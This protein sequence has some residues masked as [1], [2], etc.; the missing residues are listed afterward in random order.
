MPPGTGLRLG[1]VWCQGWLSA[2]P[3]FGISSLSLSLKVL[4]TQLAS[5]GEE[6]PERWRRSALGSERGRAGWKPHSA[7]LRLGT[8]SLQPAHANKDKN[9]GTFPI[10]I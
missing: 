10:F 4:C 1:Q 6:R 3:L 9:N 8:W 5:C 2:G 7:V